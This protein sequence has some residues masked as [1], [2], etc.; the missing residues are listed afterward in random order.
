MAV[1][2]D[3]PVDQGACLGSDYQEHLRQWFTPGQI[4]D[5]QVT[6][7]KI[8]RSAEKALHNQVSTWRS[9]RRT[10]SSSCPD[11]PHR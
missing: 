3:H 11:S 1:G 8:S 5:G 4:I 10:P 9:P 6:K 2:P 7:W